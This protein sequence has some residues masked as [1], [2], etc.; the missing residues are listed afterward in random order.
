MSWFTDNN[1]KWMERIKILLEVKGVREKFGL[2]QETSSSRGWTGPE[3]GRMD[4]F[5]DKTEYILGVGNNR[6]KVTE[7]REQKANFGNGKWFNW[8]GVH[9]GGGEE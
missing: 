3:P 9:L 6:D 1:D 2:S 7:A 5:W 8:L 4:M